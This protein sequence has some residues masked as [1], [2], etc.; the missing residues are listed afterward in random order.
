M[1]SSRAPGVNGLRVEQSPHLAKRRFQ[2]G[3]VLAVYCGSTFGR[4][5]ES[6][7]YPHGGGFTRTIG[8]EE[9]GDDARLHLEV[10]IINGNDVVVMLG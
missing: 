1:V 6:E 8:S 5:V 7:D 2:V 3:V 4:M 10:E 9:S